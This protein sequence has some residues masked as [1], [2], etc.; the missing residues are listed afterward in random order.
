MKS[1]DSDSECMEFEVND[2]KKQLNKSLIP[3]FVVSVL[4]P[5]VSEDSVVEF[6]DLSDRTEMWA[7]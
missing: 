4:N 7:E 3:S 6:D 2:V 1:F 5:S